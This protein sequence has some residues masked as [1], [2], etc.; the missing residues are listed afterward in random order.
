MSKHLL[1]TKREKGSLILRNL[2]T[3]SDPSY[4]INVMHLPPIGFHEKN[5]AFMIFW[6]NI[7][8]LGLMER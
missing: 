2:K 3:P 8:N 4:H 5:A 1:T 6:L 7:H